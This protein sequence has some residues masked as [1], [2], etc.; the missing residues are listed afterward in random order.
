MTPTMLR[1]RAISRIIPF[2]LF[3]IIGACSSSDTTGGTSGTTRGSNGAT[4]SAN[5]ECVSNLCSSKV[6][7]GNG[8]GK[9][10]NETCSVSSECASGVC[11]AGKC[12]AGQSLSN[13]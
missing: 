3:A 2:S 9:V 1:R 5:A 11:T 12:A 6:C 10:V 8:I 7:V 4:C 13:D